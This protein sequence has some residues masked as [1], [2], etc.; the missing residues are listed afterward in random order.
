MR[1]DRPGWEQVCRVEEVW[2]SPAR[3]AAPFVRRLVFPSSY[4]REARQLALGHFGT[5]VLHCYCGITTYA[6]TPGKA[7]ASHLENR[8]F[9]VQKLLRVLPEIPHQ[10]P[11]VSRQTR[12]VV[13]QLRVGE[14]F[15]NRCRVFVQFRRRSRKVRARIAKLEIGRASC[16][17]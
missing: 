16:R 4:F 13:V 12:Q 17:E 10:Q 7:A 8:D 3:S 5:L 15:P 11:H 6:A 1:P 2:I 14:K 9:N